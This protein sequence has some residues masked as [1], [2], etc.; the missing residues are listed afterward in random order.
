MVD[1]Y[2]SDG[3]GNYDLY[4]SFESLTADEL[5]ALHQQIEDTIDFHQIDSV[6]HDYF[7]LIVPYSI[8]K[9][10]LHDN[11]ESLAYY[12]YSDEMRDTDIREQ[13]I[14]AILE[15]IA[16]QPWPRNLDSHHQKEVFYQQLIDNKH[17]IILLKRPKQILLKME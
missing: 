15:Q 17:G 4:E 12:F 2:E 9:K 1:K 8:I 13:L 5:E 16:M 11:V 14:D 3:F 6:L 10:T 7:G